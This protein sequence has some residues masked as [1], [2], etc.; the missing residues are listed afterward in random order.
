MKNLPID[1]KLHNYGKIKKSNC[2]NCNKEFI[3]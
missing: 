2:I 3:Q 1:F